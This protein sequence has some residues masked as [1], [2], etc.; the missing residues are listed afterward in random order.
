MATRTTRS[1]RSKSKGGKGEQQQK[2]KEGDLDGG[3]DSHRFAKDDLM[4][5]KVKV[6][7]SSYLRCFVSRTIVRRAQ[8]EDT[9]MLLYDILPM[10]YDSIG[11][12]CDDPTGGYMA[13][14]SNRATKEDWEKLNPKQMVNRI[15]KWVTYLL[16]LSPEEAAAKVAKANAMRNN[17]STSPSTPTGSRKSAAKKSVSKKSAS[18]KSASKKPA[19]VPSTPKSVAQDENGEAKV[20]TIPKEPDSFQLPGHTD[21]WQISVTNGGYYCT[22]SNYAPEDD[23]ERANGT[24]LG[25][26]ERPGADGTTVFLLLMDRRQIGM[27]PERY[28]Y[29]MDHMRTLS[30]PPVTP[31]A[32]HRSG[33]GFN[34][35]EVARM[36]FICETA[37]EAESIASSNKKEISK[38]KRD[39]AKA[40]RDAAKVIKTVRR[41]GNIMEKG[42]I[43]QAKFR[44]E[45]EKNAARGAK[46]DEEGSVAC[47]LDMNDGV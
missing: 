33:G 2:T 22:N 14:G 12:G 40:Q 37:V 38:L 13:T 23:D 36:G 9:K 3:R 5:G 10:F 41:V 24:R 31:Q 35:R 43:E 44:R 17:A 28:L 20:H 25:V 18:K 11:P 32:A 1:T 34:E 27:V 39:V 6:E 7:G 29:S 21:Y 8:N 26:E 46:P 30:G 4:T 45:V 47:K 19:A 16:G 15:V 42:A